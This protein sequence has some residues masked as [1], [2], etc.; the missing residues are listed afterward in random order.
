MEQ[1]PEATVL[2]TV[3]IAGRPYPLRVSRDDE[4]AFRRVV[5]EINDKISDFQI[6]YSDRD[7]QDCL[8]MTVLTYAAELN[9]VNQRLNAAGATGSL[10]EQVD[11]LEELVDE[12]LK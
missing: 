5:K 10:G 1:Q 11:Q 7:K 6:S 4:T 9:K 12:L 2:L 3:I 8:A